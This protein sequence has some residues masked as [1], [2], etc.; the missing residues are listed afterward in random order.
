[1]NNGPPKDW[2]QNMPQNTSNS[3]NASNQSPWSNRGPAGQSQGQNQNQRPNWSDNS[4]SGLGQ[5]GMQHFLGWWDFFIRKDEKDTKYFKKI[6]DE[7]LL[8]SFIFTQLLP[9]Q[10]W[11]SGLLH[12]HQPYPG[13][14]CSYHSEN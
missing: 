8:I 6:L 14:K 7:K 13:C 3:Q 1:M 4:R 12:S 10:H 5:G 9:L 2:R 11:A